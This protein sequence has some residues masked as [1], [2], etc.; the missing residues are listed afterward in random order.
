MTAA[1]HARD[2]A[3]TEEQFG[4]QKYMLYQALQGSA[5]AW[6]HDL[7]EAQTAVLD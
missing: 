5:E 6:Y 7:R 3:N 2:V 4:K 1:A